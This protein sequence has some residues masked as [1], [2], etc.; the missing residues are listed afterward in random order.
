MD[1]FVNY[2]GIKQV[3]GKGWLYDDKATFCH[4]FLA[5]AWFRISWL[6][7]ST[8]WTDYTAKDFGLKPQLLLAR[9]MSDCRC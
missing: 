1:R 7:A 6:A 4:C 5:D 3:G 8:S 9:V 2:S